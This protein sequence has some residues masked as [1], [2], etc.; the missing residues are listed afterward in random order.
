M[1]ILEIIKNLYSRYINKEEFEANSI[2]YIA[3]SQT[4]PPPLSNEEEDEMLERLSK[5]DEE[6]RKT[7]V[8]R[9]L[10]LVVYISKNLKIL[11]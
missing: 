5:N 9:N 2:F 7:L 8:E 11:E 1:N 4:L 6:A 10:R 3:G